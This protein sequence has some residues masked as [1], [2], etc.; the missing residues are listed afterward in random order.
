MQMALQLQRAMM[1]LETKQ[2][3]VVIG[4][5]RVTHFRQFYD[6]PI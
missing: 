2:A 3:E 1:A 6:S 5:N 4:N